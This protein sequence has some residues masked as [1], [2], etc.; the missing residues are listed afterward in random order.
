M[1]YD[2]QGI[3]VND[4]VLPV[5]FFGQQKKRPP[6]Q[7]LVFAVVQSAFEDLNCKAL[8]KVAKA[9]DLI[10]YFYGAGK[11]VFSF[12]VACEIFELPMEKLRFVVACIAL[13][14]ARRRLSGNRREAGLLGFCKRGHEMTAHNTST[15]KQTGWTTCLK[16][17]QDR[18]RE[19]MRAKRSNEQAAA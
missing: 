12:R 14:P 6:E 17:Q 15:A 11:G 16:C 19:F 9:E 10:R 2:Q 3:L 4:A 8:R 18:N 13:A 5:Q 1:G 7:M